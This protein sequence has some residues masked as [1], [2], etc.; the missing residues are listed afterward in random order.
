MI[1]FNNAA[2]SYP[3]P[4]VVIDAVNECIR[5]MPVSQF[6]NNTDTCS[7]IIEQC[8]NSLAM[9][10][11]IK[12]PERIFFTSG[13]TES[14]NLIINGLNLKGK[15]IVTTVTEHNSLL[16]PLVNFT[17]GQSDDN[18]A[19]IDYVPCDR[20]GN[21]SV[22]E[23]EKR[24]RDNTVAVFINHC[25]NV[26]GAVQDIKR[27]GKITRSKKIL[28]I[29]DASQSAGT[30]DIEVDKSSID[31][32]V[33]TGHKGLMGSMGTGGF[34]IKPG[35]SLFLTKVGGTGQDSHIIK[36][37]T[38]YEDYEAGTM[39]LPGIAAL[40][41]GVKFILGTG[42]SHVI[43]K[44]QFLVSKLISGLQKC[45]SVELCSCNG[46][47][48]GQVVSFNIKGFPPG[49]IGYLLQQCD[50]IVRTGLHCAPLIHQHLLTGQNGNV[51]I[52]LS[53]FNT[54]QEIDSFLEIIRQTD[55]DIS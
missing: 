7:R 19:V 8:R 29:V 49:D 51:R 42:L 9:L 31:V 5:S 14:L 28:L 13:A 37:S 22:P 2:T 25:S 30:V 54:E 46:E 26:T 44:K 11:N 10:F 41:S 18:N 3:K 55:N 21:V 52:S 12:F 50:I 45:K 40:N 4:K 53:Y 16:R 47:N 33:F 48:Q 39:N 24:F 38:D 17:T 35:L 43:E 23:I 1:Y 15:H 36:L 32:L 20:F 6:R 34:Y 27:L